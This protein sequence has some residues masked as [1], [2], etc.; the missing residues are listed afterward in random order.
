MYLLWFDES[1][2][3]PR[4][5]NRETWGTRPLRTRYNLLIVYRHPSSVIWTGFIA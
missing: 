4:L 5:E 2:G 3:V 1:R